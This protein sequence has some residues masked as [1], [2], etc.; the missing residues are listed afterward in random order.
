[1]KLVAHG[2]GG[3]TVAE[4]NDNMTI[5]E[6]MLWAVYMQMEPFGDDRADWRAAMQMAQTANMNR[7]RSKAP[8]PVTKFLPKFGRGRRRA[9]TMEEM[10]AALNAQFVRLG[11]K[12][13]Q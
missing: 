4:L 11:G 8:I 2:I 7:G 13:E 9:Q 12:L 5:D 1:M 10:E 6:F 3:K